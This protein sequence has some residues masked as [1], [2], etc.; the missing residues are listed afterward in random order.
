MGNEDD[1]RKD[2]EI[3]GRYGSLDQTT[4]ED[5]ERL[6]PW[7]NMVASHGRTGE[8]RELVVHWAWRWQSSWKQSWKMVSK[9]R[10]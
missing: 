10:Q 8:T 6:P 7:K 4:G 9:K 2:K 3:V 5:E 1:Q